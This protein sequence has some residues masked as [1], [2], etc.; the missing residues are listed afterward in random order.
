M[1]RLVCVSCGN[2]VHFEVEVEAVHSVQATAQGIAVED[3]TD[4]DWIDMASTLRMGVIDVVDYCTKVDMEALRWDAE[5]GCYVNAYITCAR[6]GSRR[7]CIP[8]QPWSPPTGHVTLDEELTHNRH[9]FQ[10][11]RKERAKHADLLPQL[12]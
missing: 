1:M 5:R 12:Q 3:T 2:Y 4:I 7:V 10:W 11:L 6:C 9:E 8:Y